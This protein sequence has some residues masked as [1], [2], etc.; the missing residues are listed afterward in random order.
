MFSFKTASRI[1][2]ALSVMGMMAVAA[3]ASAQDHAAEVA[4]LGG[5]LAAAFLL[6]RSGTGQA[7]DVD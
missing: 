4:A 6:T 7:G 5:A 1:G 3:P 2:L